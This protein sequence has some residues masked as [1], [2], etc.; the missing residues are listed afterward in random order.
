MNSS[1]KQK[2]DKFLCYRLLVL[3]EEKIG[4]RCNYM[5]EGIQNS[6]N[7][8]PQADPVQKES[9]ARGDC[10]DQYGAQ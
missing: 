7:T 10:P 6:V 2:K 8:I 1:K 5:Y 3:H 9:T 4:T